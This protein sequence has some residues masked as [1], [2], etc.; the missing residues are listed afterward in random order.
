[1]LT[2]ARRSQ[3]GKV[4][5]SRLSFAELVENVTHRVDDPTTAG[6]ERYV[7][8]EHLD[9]GS[10]RIRRWGSPSDV[11]ATKL[12]FREGD[13][14]FGRRRAYQRK[15]AQADFAGICSAHAMVLRA[16]PE[17][18]VPEFLPLLMQTDYF[19]ERAL[20]I[21]V[22]GLSPTINWKTIASEEFE[23]P[24]LDE[25]RRIATMVRQADAVADAWRGVSERASVA[26][27]SALEA[28]LEG[29]RWPELACRD[30]LVRG[31][32]NG[33]SLPANDD[34]RG[35]PTLSLGAIQDGLVVPDGHTKWAEVENDRVEPYLLQRDDILVVRGNGNRNLTARCGIVSD[36]PVPYF[37]PDLLIRLVFDA[38]L[39]RPQFAALQWNS[40]TV[41]RD[42]KRRAKST[43]G[44]WKVNGKDVGQQRLRVPPLAD[45]DDFLRRAEYVQRLRDAADRR[46][47]MTVDLRHGLLERELR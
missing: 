30:T 31:P 19:F 27:A 36:L 5:W 2:E 12:V 13:V 28:M 29:G 10:L 25:Q 8:L 17:V 37:Y 6:V 43:N 38:S 35:L 46:R 18:I 14:I 33:L 41:Q 24:P 1:M 11:E 32:Q 9:P 47:Q 15:V 26:L 34:Q 4:G 40:R 16:R 39:M 23:V 20:A 45:Q 44:I 21:S 7:G 42:L 3:A 22:G